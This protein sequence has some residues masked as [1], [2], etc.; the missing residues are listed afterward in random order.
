[1]DQKFPQQVF[2]E[3]LTKYL[4]KLDQTWDDNMTAGSKNQT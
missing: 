1:M 4:A 3:D 2:A